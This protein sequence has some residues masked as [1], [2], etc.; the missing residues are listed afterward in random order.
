VVPNDR[1]RWVKGQEHVTTWKKPDS[2]WQTWFCRTCGSPVPGENNAATMFAP[3]GCIVEGGDALRVAHH[4]WVG[5]RAV[6]DEIGDAGKQ[7]PEGFR[8]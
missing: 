7:H 8:G 6:W 2:E 4:V 3:A 1:L 5:S